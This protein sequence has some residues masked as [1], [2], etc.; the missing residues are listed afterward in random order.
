M[1]IITKKYREVIR[2]N[3]HPQIDCDLSIG[4][5]VELP[6]FSNATDLE[7]VEWLLNEFCLRIS[8]GTYIGKTKEV[9]ISATTPNDCSV[10]SMPFD[11][12]GKLINNL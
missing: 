6:D 10:V 9:R 1:P 7:K 12:N 4:D 5:I 3:G 8:K 11:E 2:N